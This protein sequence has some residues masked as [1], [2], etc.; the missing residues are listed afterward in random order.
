M[1]TSDDSQHVHVEGARIIGSKF[2]SRVDAAVNVSV[3]A[4]RQ[5]LPE[6]VEQLVDAL[7]S[8]G[9]LANH[10]LSRL[11]GRLEAAADSPT[12]EPGRL[13]RA[14]ARIEDHPAVAQ[15]TPQAVT[16]AL[17]ALQLAIA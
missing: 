11:V 10:E 17:Q 6:A 1:T 4:G 3:G 12:P 13:R 5:G 15:A 7:M 9:L 16:A 8:E 2:E 14:I